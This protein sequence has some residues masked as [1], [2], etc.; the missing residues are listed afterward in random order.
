MKVALVLERFDPHRGGLEQWTMRFAAQLIRRGHEVHVVATRFDPQTRAVPIIPHQLR[1]VGPRRAFAEAAQA[2]LFSLAPQVIHD[3]GSGW[4]CDVF[5]PHGGSWASVTQRKLLLYPHWF[6]PLKRRV[7]RL[8]RRQREFRALMSRQYA[9]NGQILVALS[10]TV[11][12]DFRRFHGVPPERIRVVYN[13]V[14]TD[15]FSPA[16]RPT[17]REA[18]RRELGVGDET[19]LALIVAHNFRLKGVPTLLRA[20]RRLTAEAEPVHLAVLGGKRLP[21]WRRMAGRLGVENAVS[22]VGPKTDTTP[23]YAAADVYVHPTF[24]DTCSLVVLEAAASGLPIVTSR[25]NGVSELLHDGVEGLL[26]S[27]PADADELAGQLRILLDESLRLK[28]GRAARQTALKHTLQRNV[29]E[30]LAVYEEV[31]STRRAAPATAK[32]VVGSGWAARGAG[33]GTGGRRGRS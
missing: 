15:Q 25:L 5:H 24:Y 6:R 3:M 4:Y 29:E 27:D 32:P 26:I 16:H 14:D 11:A 2:K 1:D 31:V 13:G 7:D 28:M 23:Y 10:H 17:Y 19:L 22:F 21:F 33:V 18:V 20:M 9:D 8:L 12:D 30:I